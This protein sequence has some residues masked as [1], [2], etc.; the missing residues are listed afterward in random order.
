MAKQAK[1]VLTCP[2][3]GHQQAEP[4]AAFSAVCKECGQYWRVQDL[5]K[6]SRKAPEATPQRRQIRCFDCGTEFE[7]AVSAQ[8][9]MCKRC[10]A[11]IDLHDYDIT[12]AVSKNFK[13]KGTFVIQ[14][15][16]YVFNTEAIVAEAVI[17]GRF[18][19]KLTVE[20]T[21]TLHSTAEIKG[22]FT[23]AHLL[24]PAGQHFRWNQEIQVG[25]VEIGGELVAN[26]HADSILVQPKGRL[27]GAVTAR[28]IIAEAGGVLVGEARISNDEA[29]K[30][31]V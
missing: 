15:S 4:K 28:S 21:L 27:F 14:P 6:P 9:T 18:L 29:G 24:I 5:L 3:C 22:S 16:G 2:R 25:S 17:K 31:Q 23:A 7:V 8:S 19:G 10:S 1:A 13:T 12:Q 11:Y 30:P 20:G 26:V